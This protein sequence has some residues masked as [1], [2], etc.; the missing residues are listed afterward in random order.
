MKCLHLNP[1]NYR[2]LNEGKHFQTFS[3][4]KIFVNKSKKWL[5]II[6][7]LMSAVELVGVKILWVHLKALGMRM[8]KLVLGLSLAQILPKKINKMI[9]RIWYGRFILIAAVDMLWRERLF[10]LQLIFAL[11]AF[12]FWLHT[13]IRL[14]SIP[15]L[16]TKYFLSVFFPFL[17]F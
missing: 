11:L 12:A 4:V 6:L 13:F 16:R 14:Y 10:W 8:W 1:S 5:K 15:F 9:R 7:C 2:Y 17:I 3:K